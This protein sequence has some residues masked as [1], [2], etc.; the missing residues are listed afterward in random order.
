NRPAAE[1]AP[2]T[3]P[4]TRGVPASLFCAARG[5]GPN[6]GR[7]KRARHYWLAT[8]KSGKHKVISLQGGY[9]GGTTGTFAVCGLPHLTQAY[10][11][12]HVPGFAKVTPPYPYRDRG[13]GTTPSSCSAGRAS[14][15][16][17]S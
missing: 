4:L 12:L 3:P 5:P 11:H 14:C 10:A 7:M 16:R 9:H 17:R 1:R 13:T 6:G 2:K 8:G 15:A